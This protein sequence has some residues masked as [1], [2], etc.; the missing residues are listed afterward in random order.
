MVGN[1]KIKISKLFFY[2]SIQLP[3]I[4]LVYLLIFPGIIPRQAFFWGLLIFSCGLVVLGLVNKDIQHKAQHIAGYISI[5]I[6]WILILIF[7]VPWAN[8]QSSLLN[9][10][11]Y[12]TPVNCQ[13][14]LSPG[15]NLA[16]CDLSGMDLS[17]MDLSAADL[18]SVDFTGADLSS[19]ILVKANL[20]NADLFDVDLSDTDLSG[21]NLRF[22][23]LKNA[24]LSNTNLTDADLSGVDLTDTKFDNTIVKDAIFDRIDPRQVVGLSQ[25]DILSIASWLPGRKYD[26]EAKLIITLVCEEDIGFTD[27][28]NYESGDESVNQGIAYS[29][30]GENREGWNGF[31]SAW[32]EGW[33]FRDV[34]KEAYIACIAS[35]YEEMT[36]SYFGTK[37][38]VQLMQPRLGVEIHS[39]QTGEK[40]VSNEF[41]G[42][43][44]SCP[45]VIYPGSSEKL[46]VG[47]HNYS[48][49]FAW[50]AEI[51]GLKL[52]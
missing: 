5:F 16:D 8:L 51:T 37:S 30:Y 25:E 49:L 12:H 14:N 11:Q 48:G 32:P 45:E 47:K 42:L 50:L 20:E 44:V 9:V 33:T 19:T 28:I 29:L 4:V 52:P 17:H 22:V 7:W 38:T 21:A 2:L 34:R 13:N 23:D 40:L 27:M 26:Q 3:I 41:D 1:K 18:S 36:C 31:K 35:F 39:W 24:L 6:S 46:Y 43:G 15:A 10:Y